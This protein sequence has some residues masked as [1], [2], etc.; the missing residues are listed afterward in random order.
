MSEPVVRIQGVSKSYGTASVLRDLHLEIRA[1]QFVGL[2]GV[3]GAGKT[4]L[5]KCMVDFCDFE[6]GTIEI[7][8]VAHR[9]PEARARL[10]FLPERFVPPYFL[11]GRE[12]LDVMLRLAGRR[13][14][15][16]AEHVLGVL[17]VDLALL[18]KPVAAYSKGMTQKLGLA[19]CFLS[20]RELYLLDE[21]MGGL[22]PKARAQV[23]DLLLREKSKGRTAFFTT[24]S[25][26]D[27]E[28]ICDHMAVLHEGRLAFFG[29]PPE[30]REQQGE[31]TLEQA[32]L[33]CIRTPDTEHA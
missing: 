1:G 11:T 17:D 15:V 21:P 9:R 31:R 12:F 4:T 13:P 7:H 20:G 28:E 18:R 3:N 2:A 22:D 25:L 10:A 24:H 29:S 5:L 33:K 23:K 27:I 32:F 16:A 30:L 6:S 8:G 26:A 14:D 19:A